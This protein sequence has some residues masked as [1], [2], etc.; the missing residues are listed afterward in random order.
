MHGE[1]SIAFGGE[2]AGGAAVGKPPRNP[3][4]KKRREER[5]RK[6]SMGSGRLHVHLLF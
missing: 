3:E 5:R 6:A 4:R 2:V 1:V